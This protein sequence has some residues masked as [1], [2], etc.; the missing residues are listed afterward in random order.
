M[1]NISVVIVEDELIAAEFL[2]EILAQHG[3]EVLGIVDTGEEAIRFCSEACPDV[4]FMDIMLRDSVSGSEAALAISRK[5][6]SKIIFLTAFVDDEM[7]DYAVQANAAGYLTKPYNEAQII[8]TMRLAVQRADPAASPSE[9]QARA[10]IAL[11]N[12][13][14]Y[15]PQ[16]NRL[17]KAGKEVELGPRA[18]RLVGLLCTQPDISVSNEQIVTHVWGEHVN[19]KTL[20]SLVFRIRSVLGED[21]IRNVSGAGYMICSEQGRYARA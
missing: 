10:S 8:A 19:D 14:V 18:M 17:L 3:A 21:L 12:D 20:R 16:E 13:F 5:C 4:I 6:P 7:V 15:L 1:D 2:K 11:K 9:D